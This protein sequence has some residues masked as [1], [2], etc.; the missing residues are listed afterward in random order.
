MI[1]GLA[2]KRTLGGGEGHTTS[3]TLPDSTPTP[4]EPVSAS[5]AQGVVSGASVIPAVKQS[6]SIPASPSTSLTGLTAGVRPD[7]STQ[8]PLA[9]SSK[10]TV[11]GPDRNV[12]MVMN[13]GDG[14]ELEGL[15]KAKRAKLSPGEETG[16][17]VEG[18]GREVG[19]EIWSNGTGIGKL[20]KL[21]KRN[22]QL[23]H[24][25]SSVERSPSPSFQASPSPSPAPSLDSTPLSSRTI[26]PLPPD[27]PPA[28]TRSCSSR[29]SSLPAESSGVPSSSSS[30]APSAPSNHAP[31]PPLLDCSAGHLTNTLLPT[32]ENVKTCQWA[33]CRR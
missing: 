24:R 2:K 25:H 7:Y 9:I 11:G 5:S 23:L 14:L 4:S 17:G 19:S 3:L 16:G 26:S 1:A 18:I 21:V 30:L 22:H 12:G 15:P 31:M 8:S 13:G 29:A 20:E 27:T 32:G 6:F 10:A 33:D 28:S